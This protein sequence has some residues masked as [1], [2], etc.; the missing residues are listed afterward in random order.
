MP[1]LVH[2][3]AALVRT[4]MSGSSI[5]TRRTPKAA[6]DGRPPTTRWA[7][8]TK[9]H[10][11]VADPRPTRSLGL[12]FFLPAVVIAVVIIAVRA[13]P[14]SATFPGP[15]GRIAFN[16]FVKT[17]E[18]FG[19]FTATPDGGDVR[20]LISTPDTLSGIPDWSP[21]GERIAFFTES[22]GEVHEPAQV[23][24]MN[25]D[26]SGV[27]QLTSG[28]G[29]KGIPSWSPDAASLAIAADW[30]DETGALQGIWIIP[31]SDPDG[32]TQEEALRVTARPA[33]FDADIDPAFS[34]DGNSIAFTRLKS[35]RKS[36]V[37]RVGIDGT[38]LERLTKWKLN[39]SDPDWSPDGQMIT[40]DSGDSGFPG[41][42]GDI[43]VMG[44][45]GS[46]RTRLTDSPR[47]RVGKRLRLAQNPVWAPS[48]TKIMYTL[49]KA[50]R[51]SFPPGG[52]LVMIN[53]DGSGKQVVVDGRNIN[54]VDWG[55]HP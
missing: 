34:P 9:C 18:S 21:D 19:I 22:F 44:A 40:F 23:H 20:K 2:F 25:A 38:G 31:A 29:F 41:S 47:L 51:L 36:A 32:V 24:A 11:R 45:D 5:T 26:G 15:D 4:A 6:I 49:F 8:S 30:G 54:K 33:G 53:P 27:T 43:Y 1:H 16:A 35:E 12:R 13:A 52:P 7:V 10:F 46:G 3:A 48:G 50:R 17:T 28:P 37:V 39:A 55:T 14:A 42:K